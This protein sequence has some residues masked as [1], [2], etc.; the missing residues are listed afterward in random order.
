[1]ANTITPNGDGTNDE[2]RFEVLDNADPDFFPDNEIIIFNRWGDIV[3]KAR[4]YNNDWRGQNTA[5]Q[6]LPHA[7]YYYILRLDISRGLIIEGDITI[8]K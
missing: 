2:L 3:F 8:L 7:T 4:P 1:V 6:E 5:G